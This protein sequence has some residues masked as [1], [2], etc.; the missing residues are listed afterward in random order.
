MFTWNLLIYSIFATHLYEIRHQL[1]EWIL[2]SVSVN[3]NTQVW[4]STAFSWKLSV[5]HQ[6]FCT[7]PWCICGDDISFLLNTK[8]NSQLR[9][10]TYQHIITTSVVSVSVNNVTKWHCHWHYY[11]P[12]AAFTL[13][14]TL[15]NCN[16]WMQASPPLKSAFNTVHLIA[17][18]Q[19][20]SIPKAS[21]DEG[22]KCSVKLL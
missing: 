19:G 14:F 7:V 20:R 17:G 16:M 9:Y 4:Q 13:H 15:T 8:G 10:Y 3:S 2:H 18:W 12:L 21:R 5:A 22:E 11:Q 1:E 6:I